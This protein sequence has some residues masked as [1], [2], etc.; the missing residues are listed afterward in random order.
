M[1][2]IS[3]DVSEVR[4]L[5]AD[6]KRN[7][8]RIEPM[9]KLIVAKTGHDLVAVAQTIVPVDTGNL[10]N[11]IGVDVNGL[12]FEA[13]P[14]ADYGWYVEGGTSRMHAEPYMGPAADRVLPQVEDALAQLG[15]HILDRGA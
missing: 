15:I 11:S 10:K 5:A 8:A 6:M 2:S 13:G 3:I 12:E 14:T 9:A 4:D 7:A 1:V